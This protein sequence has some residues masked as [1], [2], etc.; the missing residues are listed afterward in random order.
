MWF[1]QD[2]RFPTFGNLNVFLPT[3]KLRTTTRTTPPPTYV[4]SGKAPI[5]S[6]NTFFFRKI[7][8]TLFAALT[9]PC[10]VRAPETAHEV[11]DPIAPR[12]PPL[13]RRFR[14]FEP[15]PQAAVHLFQLIQ[16]LHA[17]CAQTMCSR[18]K[19][20]CRQTT[21]KKVNVIIS[22]FHYGHDIAAP[23]CLDEVRRVQCPIPL[24]RTRD[25]CVL[26]KKKQRVLQ[27]LPKKRR[28]DAA[29]N[30]LTYSTYR[31]N[32]GSRR[33]VAYESVG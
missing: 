11:N 12:E 26:D 22:A 33:A 14:R 25:G 16:H 20:Q 1:C 30:G 8:P 2:S 19:R 5:Q 21:P 31:D 7:A 32:T 29:I 24:Y 28:W 15:F 13:V 4:V 23:P 18:H 6:I 17:R 27:R 9:L 3:T 10:A